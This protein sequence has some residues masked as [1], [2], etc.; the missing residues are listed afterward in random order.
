MNL[1]FEIGALIFSFFRMALRHAS[2]LTC[3]ARETLDVSRYVKVK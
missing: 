3:F 1:I 2:L